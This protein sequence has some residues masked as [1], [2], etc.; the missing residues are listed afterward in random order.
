MKKTLFL[1]LLLAGVLA[2]PARAQTS[3]G[4]HGGYDLDFEE[5]LIGGQARFGLGTLPLQF[6]P[7]LDFF[8]ADR[9]TLLQFDGNFLYP[10]SG[11]PGEPFTPYAG[12][13]LGVAYRSVGDFDDTS[14]GLNLLAGANFN[15]ATRIRPF[16]QAR[17][18]VGDGTRVGVMGGIL[19]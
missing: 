14:A 1:S 18:T 19:F 11:G 6:Q 2:F 10:I 9:G 7:G 8:F 3:F 4:F 17:L 16:I 12:A 5:F 15:S 13:G